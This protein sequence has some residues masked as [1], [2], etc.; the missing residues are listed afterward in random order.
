MLRAFQ[1][2]ALFAAGF[3]AKGMLVLYATFA[4]ALILFAFASVTVLWAGAM[5]IALL[6]AADAVTVAVRQTTVQLTTPDHMRGRAHAFMVLAAQTANNV[7][8]LWV[9]FWAEWI[10]A[11]ETML[12]GAVLALLA[13]FLIW[14]AW[15]PILLRP[16]SS[17]I[18]RL[19]S[20]MKTSLTPLTI[21]A[22]LP[23]R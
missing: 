11:A 19:P 22:L 23:H 20:E 12:L 7:G 17:S 5:M 10:G 16:S 15:R 1:I 9:G 8:T 3:R 21:E 6:G 13:T 14:R 4:Y 18:A 2:S